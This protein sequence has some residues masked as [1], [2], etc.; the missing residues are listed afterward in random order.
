MRVGREA[1][2]KP[3]FA[4]DITENKKNEQI[5]GEQFVVATTSDATKE[6]LSLEMERVSSLEQAASLPLWLVITRLIA[7]FYAVLY[8]TVLVRFMIDEG[9]SA[10]LRKAVQNTPVLLVLAFLAIVLVCVLSMIASKRKAAVAESEETEKAADALDELMAISYAE[11]NVPADAAEMDVLFFRY[12]MKDGEPVVKSV[13]FQPFTHFNVNMKVYRTD[14]MLMLSD[15][16]SVYAFPVSALREIRTVKK[17]ISVHTWNKEQAPNEAP[18]AAYKLTVNPNLGAIF[19]KPYHVLLL[20][21]EGEELGIL[22]PPYELPLVERL[23]GL[24][25]VTEPPAEA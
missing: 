15:L 9:V 13:G 16:D 6:R 25:A 17:K 24:T 2:V 20:E 10:A 8:F 22:F 1:E 5:N 23:T 21:V 14:D 7:V 4:I 18:Y 19:F 12:K 3:L 11:L